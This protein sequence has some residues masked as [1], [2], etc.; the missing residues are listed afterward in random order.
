M[1]LQK[2]TV[3]LSIWDVSK[4]ALESGHLAGLFNLSIL[5]TIIQMAPILLVGWLPR[6]REEL[7]ELNAKPYSGS[8]WGGSAFLLILAGSMAYTLTVTILNITRPGWSGGS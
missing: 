8:S 4:E 5:T 2:G 1:F 3:L 6:S 7:W